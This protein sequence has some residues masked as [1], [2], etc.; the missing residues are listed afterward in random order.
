MTTLDE[1]TSQVKPNGLHRFWNKPTMFYVLPSGRRT[2]V[3]PMKILGCIYKEWF[4][5]YDDDPNFEFGGFF[6]D[7]IQITSF[8]PQSA[9]DIVR[10]HKY[11]CDQATQRLTSPDFKFKTR[12]YKL[13]PLY[14]AINSFSISWMT[15]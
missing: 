3:C 4:L 7:P 1:A 12:T 5:S 13:L 14:K 15:P 8:C 9:A 11:L 6:A 2:S 10:S